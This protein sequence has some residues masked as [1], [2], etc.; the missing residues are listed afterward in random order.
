MPPPERQSRLPFA[1]GTALLL[2]RPGVVAQRN[3]D[4]GWVE[5]KLL[6]DPKRRNLAGHWTTLI[7]GTSI[8]SKK[9]LTFTPVKAR[10]F[11]LVIQEATDTP[12]VNEFQLFGKGL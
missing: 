2:F 1:C 11:R 6:V 4:G 10:L 7:T 5:T 8:G 3:T 9:Q 12:V